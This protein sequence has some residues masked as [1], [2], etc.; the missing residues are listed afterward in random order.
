[1]SEQ[2]KL[3]EQQTKLAEQRWKDRKITHLFMPGD[4]TPHTNACI[5]TYTHK[6]TYTHNHY[7]L[8][9]KEILPDWSASIPAQ[10]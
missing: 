7:Q 5:H 10:A 2:R 1:M 6:Y 4:Y 9:S 3:S 8:T